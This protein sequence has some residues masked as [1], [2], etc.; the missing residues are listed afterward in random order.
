MSY[1]HVHGD[2]YID[3]LISCI[4]RDLYIDQ[5]ISCIIN[6]FLCETFCIFFQH[7][8]YICIPIYT[9]ITQQ[10]LEAGLREGERCPL[11]HCLT[12]LLLVV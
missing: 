5:L 12:L 6:Y 9:C 1:V 11:T 10:S 3:Q 8:I 4:T 7:A 2:L